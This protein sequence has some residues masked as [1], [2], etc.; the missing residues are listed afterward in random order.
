MME[1]TA[2]RYFAASNSCRGFCNY[3][4]ELFTEQN[5][6]RL[7]IIKGGPGTGKS[8]FMKVVAR[9]ARL[10]GYRVTEY[11]CSS[12]PASLDG[13]RLVREGCPSVGLL[14]GT[15]PHVREPVLPGV[16]EEM[17]NLGAFWNHRM[18]AEKEDSI[19]RLACGKSAAY[20]R[21]YAY[22]AACGEVDRAVESRMDGCVYEA[23]LRALAERILRHQPRGG[24]FSATPAIR[25][26]VG[27]TGAVC[28]HTLDPLI[29]SQTKTLI[30]CDI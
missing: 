8:Y 27:M 6:D 5:T 30:L 14:D 22:L 11:A 29:K 19:R 17:V 25:R 12:D 4:G 20:D 23:R 1:S 15:A 3:Y 10:R 9:Q 13:V 7:Y 18:L 24:G 16:K 26:A 2:L 21:A 28:L